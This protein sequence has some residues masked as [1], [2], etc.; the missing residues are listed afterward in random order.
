M[1]IYGSDA[2]KAG[3]QRECGLIDGEVSETAIA[4]WRVKGSSSCSKEASAQ[5]FG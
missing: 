4:V 5:G 1:I 3:L 2:E